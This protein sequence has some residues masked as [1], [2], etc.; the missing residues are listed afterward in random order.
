[1]YIK[2]GD[3]GRY[4]MTSI[5]TINFQSESGSP[6]RLKD[7]M[8]IQGLKKNIISVAVLEDHGYD[9]IFKKGK[10]FLRHIATR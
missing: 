6:L 8:F 4:N 7:V 1:M 3:D 10:T 2:L 9:V 5:G